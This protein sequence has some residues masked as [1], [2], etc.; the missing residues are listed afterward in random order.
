MRRLLLAQEVTEAITVAAT[1]VMT[2]TATAIA[3]WATKRKDH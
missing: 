2:A 3:M 1:L